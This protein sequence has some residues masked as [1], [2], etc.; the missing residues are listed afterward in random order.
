[1]ED[2]GCYFFSGFDGSIISQLLG[3][4]CEEKDNV[5]RKNPTMEEVLVKALTQDILLN[6]KM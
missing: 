5:E 4:E 1:M 2:G 3:T 6:V